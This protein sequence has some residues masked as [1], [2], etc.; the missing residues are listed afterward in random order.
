MSVFIP[1]TI[2]SSNK[3]ARLT[4]YDGSVSIELPKEYLERILEKD[5]VRSTVVI[6]NKS[7]H[8]LSRVLDR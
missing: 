7:N 8:T 3:E 2:E 4:I 6:E 5:F 1:A